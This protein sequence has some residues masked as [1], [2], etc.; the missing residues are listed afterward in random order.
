MTKRAFQK[1]ERAEDDFYPTPREAVDSLFPYLLRDHFL[2]DRA[3]PFA[4]PCYGDGSLVEHL[5]TRGLQ[6]V[7]RGDINSVEEQRDA[8]YWTKDDYNGAK[9]VITNPPWRHDIMVSIMER[10]SDHLPSWFLIYSD[11]L[12]THQSALAM[13]ERCTDVV[14][15]GRLKWIKGSKSV[16]FDNCCWVRM[17]KDKPFGHSPAKFWPMRP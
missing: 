15:V 10:Q 16:G 8:R 17:W 7:A 14:P 12:F 1:F 13:K 9:V 2:R 11:W 4:E 3:N 5:E 6:C